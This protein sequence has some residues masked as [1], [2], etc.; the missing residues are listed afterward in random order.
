MKLTN[1][2]ATY[3]TFENSYLVLF[4][5]KDHLFK[6][7]R[8][9]ECQINNLLESK[10]Y[11]KVFQA[12]EK[13]ILETNDELKAEIKYYT[14]PEC[15]CLFMNEE[16]KGID[17]IQETFESKDYSST[18]QDIAKQILEFPYGR[19]YDPPIKII[20]RNIMIT[21]DSGYR[22]V[23]FPDG[24]IIDYAKEYTDDFDSLYS[25]TVQ[26]IEDVNE[27]IK[28]DLHLTCYKAKDNIDTQHIYIHIERN[29]ELFDS[30]IEVVKKVLEQQKRVASRMNISDHDF[31][32]VAWKL[33]VNQIQKDYKIIRTL[34]KSNV[35]QD[36]DPLEV[37]N[38]R[39]YKPLFE[40]LDK[41]NVGIDDIE[42]FIFEIL[43]KMSLNPFE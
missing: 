1:T 9:D 28:N 43:E 10:S 11:F 40:Y 8:Y 15:E 35:L 26:L 20:M 18:I 5:R 4:D 12:F 21:R 29:D 7:I 13:I 41:F 14:L 33:M 31:K 25:H 42:E 17:M 23:T 37:L 6:L 36:V 24:Y 19:D 34:L 3:E 2:I 27:L 22:T 30:C 39:F 16:I 32:K 38:I